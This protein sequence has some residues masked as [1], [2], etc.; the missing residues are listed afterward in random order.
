MEGRKFI[1]QA[2]RLLGTKLEEDWRTAASRAYYGLLLECR[3]ALYRWGFRFPKVEVHRAVRL[4]FDSRTLADIQQIAW[5]L[6]TLSQLRSKADYDLTSS[7]F[8]SDILAVKA[9]RSAEDSIIH[10]DTL[11]A[12]PVRRAA[13]IADIKSRWP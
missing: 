7:R 4:R 11:E 3:D 2:R 9:V 8:A 5:V 1:A 13:A 6:D 10:F 12:D